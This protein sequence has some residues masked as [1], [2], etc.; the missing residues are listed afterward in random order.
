MAAADRRH[1]NDRRGG[2]FQ[3]DAAAPAPAAPGWQCAAFGCP[4]AGSLADG[5]ERPWL[6]RYHID[7]PPLARDRLTR[8]IRH[9]QPVLDFAGRLLRATSYDLS[10]RDWRADIPAGAP[11]P[12]ADEHPHHY[13]HALLR[14]AEQRIRPPIG[15][16][17]TA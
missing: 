13:A 12:A 6:C 5:A 17:P 8:R 9:Y 3:R 15:Q 16:T 11:G 10:R 7:V 1:G 4:L 2:P 14:W